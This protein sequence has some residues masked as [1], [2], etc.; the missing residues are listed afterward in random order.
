MAGAR[1][2]AVA[3]T[4][5]L[6]ASPSPGEEVT[7]P[8]G[9][10]E[11]TFL[12][13]VQPDVRIDVRDPSG[14]PVVGSAVAHS[15]D[16]RRA[17]V[18]FPAQD[19]AGDYVVEYRYVALDGD[20]S[21]ETYRF[22]LLPPEQGEDGPGTGALAGVGAVVVVLLVGLAVALRRRRRPS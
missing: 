11:L 13:P 3:H 18:T 15:E 7:G 19:R 1:G 12:D 21:R 5:V 20:A 4:D 6:R 16:G 10:V 22:T 14:R 8:V 2:P 17:S 9:S